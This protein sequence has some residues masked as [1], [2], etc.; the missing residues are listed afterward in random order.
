MN[1]PEL[2]QQYGIALAA[3]TVVGVSLGL[4]SKALFNELKSRINRS[5]QQV[6]TVVPAIDRLTAAIESNTATLEGNGKLL[7]QVLQALLSKDGPR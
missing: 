1:F 7:H 4:V 5:E 2:A 3:L 6:D